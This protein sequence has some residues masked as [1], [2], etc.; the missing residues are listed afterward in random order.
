[1]KANIVIGLL[2]IALG[3]GALVYKSVNYTS[4]ETVLKVGPLEATAQTEKQ[5]D[6]P[7]WVGILSVVAGVAVLVL[8][9]KR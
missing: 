3:L 1:M 6:I 8:G 7:G 5:I 2:L 9:R 4:E